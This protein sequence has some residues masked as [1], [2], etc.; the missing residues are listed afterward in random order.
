MIFTVELKRIMAIAGIFGVFESKFRHE[1]KLYP[2]ILLQVDESSKVSFH[3]VI[4]F[5]SFAIYLK[6]KSGL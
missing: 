1:K 2:I 4:L 5:F 3:C 6:V